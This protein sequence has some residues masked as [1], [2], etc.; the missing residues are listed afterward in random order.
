MIKLRNHS[1]MFDWLNCW[2]T[3]GVMVAESVCVALIGPEVIVVFAQATIILLDLQ[4]V[5]RQK[6]LGE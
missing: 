3:R 4:L 2:T 6:L 1:G 5:L